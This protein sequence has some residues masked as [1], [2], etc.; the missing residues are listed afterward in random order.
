M[1]LLDHLFHD[2]KFALRQLRKNPAFT[3]TAILVLALGLCAS[4]AIFSF[5]DAAL[6]KPLPYR[7]PARLVGVYE[8]IPLCERC[9]L[10]Y[11]DYLD[12]KGMNKTLSSLEIYNQAG[13]VGDS[14]TGAERVPGAR[15]SAG[16]F[17]TLGVSPILGRDFAAGEDK[18]GG[19][20]LAIVSY[21]A[22][23]ARYGGRPDVIGKSVRF[24]GISYTIIGVLPADFH[25]APVR[26]AAVWGLIRGDNNCERRR[27]C[28]NLY[29]VG[30]LKD[31]VT[32]EAASADFGVIARN[33]QAQYPDSNTGQLS[34]IVPLSEVI[35]GSIQPVLLALLGGSALLLLIAAV[36]VA[37]LLLVRSE[38][39]KREIAVRSGLGASPSRLA[40]QFVTEGLLLIA[41]SAVLGLGAAHWAAILLKR[42]IPKSMLDGMPFLSELGLH[43]RELEF[44]GIVSLLAAILFTVTPAVRLSLS[45]SRIESSRGYSGAA[46]RKLGAHMVILELATASV[47]LIGAGLLGKSL[48]RVL[49]VDLGLRPDH[50]AVLGVGGIGPSYSKNEQMIALNREL[51]RRVSTIP[52]V[53]S[54]ASSSMFPI[55]GGN[56]VWLRFPDR[57]DTGAHN[58]VQQ[59]QV[60][61]NYFSTLGARMLKGRYFKESD[62]ST[63]PLVVIV[64]KLFVDKYYPGKDPLDQQF[65][66]QS[67]QTGPFTIVGVV[68]TIKE[69]ALDKVSWPTMYTPFNQNPSSFFNLIARTSQDEHALI[70]AMAA[71]I[72]VYDRGLMAGQSTTLSDQINDSPAA[73]LRRSSAWLAAGFAGLALILGVV[74]LYG[75]IAYS[76]SQRTREIGVR[77]A[78]GAQMST[79]YRMI[80][81]EAAWLIGIGVALGLA[82]SIGAAALIRGLL[83]GTKS[84][85]LE[86]FGSVT[87]V[88]VLSALI[89]SFIPARRAAS[90]NPVDAL[91][92]E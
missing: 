91:R 25:F 8:R 50:V 80:M 1:A 29:G 54:V 76:V 63:K 70:P 46:W 33:L 14:P 92:S 28:H 30:R 58:E 21:A 88:L 84:W 79:V 7:R 60:T 6:L 48:Y 71:T 24:N 51:L 72:H 81:K 16:F 9:N 43:A 44:V 68:D 62:D 41:A 19:S 89:A 5:V 40:M 26:Q 18:P 2:L 15:V 49:Q 10:S 78:L 74:G 39:R 34:S 37:N 52:G 32:L 38:G 59:R 3:A 35:V 17:R 75:V 22:W 20:D 57:P 11:L 23:Q 73:Y 90:V 27:S 12:W 82:A 61:E 85:D 45:G 87:T 77:I 65:S 47:L 83:F 36:N 31:D 55:S 69:G 56:T 4:L 67:I 42:L 64:D 66:F 13:Y 53:Q 86:T